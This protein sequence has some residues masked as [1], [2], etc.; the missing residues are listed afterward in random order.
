[1]SVVV[2][3]L[4]PL[5]KLEACCSVV[6]TFLCY[7]IQYAQ[8]EKKYFC[9]HKRKEHFLLIKGNLYILENIL[10]RSRMW[11]KCPNSEFC[12]L[13]ISLFRL[14]MEI[15]RV[16]LCIQFEYGKILTRKNS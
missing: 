7:R 10:K 11:G 6:F 15:Y 4:V 9:K 16:T 8:K 3:L 13:C 2:T 5:C 1:M 12:C 14:N